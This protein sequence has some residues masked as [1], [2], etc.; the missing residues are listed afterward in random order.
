M[1]LNVKPEDVDPLWQLL[2]GIRDAGHE[3]PNSLRALTR[4]VSQL[5]RARQAESQ[6]R[7]ERKPKPFTEDDWVR[8]FRIRCESKRGGKITYAE[9]MFCRRAWEQ[10]PERYDRMDKE[11]FEATKPFGA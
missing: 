7:A 6:P 9:S 3:E 10:D 5:E 1:K 11:V 8:V 4:L 2:T